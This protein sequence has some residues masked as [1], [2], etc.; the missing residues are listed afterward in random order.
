MSTRFQQYSGKPIIRLKK[1]LQK[2]ID[3][4]VIYTTKKLKTRKQSTKYGFGQPMELHVVYELACIE[5]ISINVVQTYRQIITRIAK[6]GSVHKPV[7]QL[8]SECCDTS[9]EF[10]WRITD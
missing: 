7:C 6:L 2:I 1:K 10:D 5:C 8:V 9:C 4:R 3:L